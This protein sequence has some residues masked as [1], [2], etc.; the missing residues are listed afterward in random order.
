[1][2][3]QWPVQARIKDVNK[4]AL[5]NGCG[6][7]S[8]NLCGQHLFAVNAFCVSIFGTPQALFSLFAAFTHRWEV[9]I[10]NTEVSVKR[11]AET[12]LSA[13]YEPVKPVS[14]KLDQFVD[15]IE[16]LCDQSENLER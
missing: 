2:H 14:K 8:L 15:S 5:F 7:Y 3:P 9:L 12:L 4:K 16:A 6:S 1:M 13:H 10:N 11:L